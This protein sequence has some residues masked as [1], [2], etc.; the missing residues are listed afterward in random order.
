MHI[1]I[2]SSAHHFLLTS[3]QKYFTPNL[4]YSPHFFLVNL[5]PLPLR[6]PPTGIYQSI[7][8][9]RLSRLLRQSK[10]GRRVLR[11]QRAPRSHRAHRTAA[12]AQR[13]PAGARLQSAD[14]VGLSHCG[15]EPWT[16]TAGGDREHWTD[17]RRSGGDAQAVGQVRRR[18]AQVV[19]LTGKT[20]CVGYCV[21]KTKMYKLHQFV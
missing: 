6:P 2:T 13:L 8:P 20:L 9:A 15:P 16:R 17:A 21:Y 1:I 4:D 3:F 12:G 14:T 19:R 11:R 5:C 18:V 10:T 7:S